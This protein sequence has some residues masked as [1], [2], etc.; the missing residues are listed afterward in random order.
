MPNAGPRPMPPPV[1]YTPVRPVVYV[2][3]GRPYTYRYVYYP[4]RVY[5]YYPLYI[6]PMYWTR[7]PCYQTNCQARYNQCLAMYGNDG[8]VCYPGFLQCVQ[9]N[10]YNDYTPA[11]QQCQSAIPNANRC[12]LTCAPQAYPDP[13]VAPVQYS[14]YS[15]LWIQ[16]ANAT[17]FQNYAYAFSETLAS[18]LSSNGNG[19]TGSSSTI[20][21]P[22]VDMANITLSEVADVVVN[23]TSLLQIDLLIKRPTFEALNITATKLNALVANTSIEFQNALVKA[24]VLFETTQLTVQTAQTSVDALDSNGQVIAPND[25]SDGVFANAGAALCPTM[26]VGLVAWVCLIAGA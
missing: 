3:V 9:T 12:V 13:A 22:P 21:N 20:G 11:Y 23:D 19:S 2:P 16:G 17:G 4:P 24:G 15:T 7:Y 10:C 25:S 14:L 26:L 18:Y 6:T 1:I 8:C 5:V